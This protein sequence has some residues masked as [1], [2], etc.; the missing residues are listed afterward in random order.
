MKKWALI[1]ILSFLTSCGV[2]NELV[3]YYDS[4]YKEV[5]VKEKVLVLN[6]VPYNL[7]YRHYN[8]YDNLYSNTMFIKRAKYYDNN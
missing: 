6:H 1:L 3:G 7:M 2:E 4:I 5:V 8:P